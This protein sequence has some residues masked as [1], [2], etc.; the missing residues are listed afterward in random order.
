MGSLPECSGPASTPTHCILVDLRS[1]RS[2]GVG[3]SVR[4]TTVLRLGVAA[5]QAS[6]ELRELLQA[7]H[8]DGAITITAVDSAACVSSRNR[9]TRS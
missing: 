3:N 1:F 8:S 9:T 4:T 7:M 6:Q 2:C 5:P